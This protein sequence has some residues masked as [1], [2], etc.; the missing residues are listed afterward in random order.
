MAALITPARKASFGILCRMSCQ[1]YVLKGHPLTRLVRAAE[2][3][4]SWL[5]V[6]AVTL[7]L[8]RKYGSWAGVAGFAGTAA[9][10][11]R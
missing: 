4:L 5:S 9:G 8:R 11:S 6:T 1:Q 3:T 7:L 2:R 10:R